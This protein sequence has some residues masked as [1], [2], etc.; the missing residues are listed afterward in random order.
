MDVKSELLKK[1]DAPAGRM[2]VDEHTHLILEKP[3]LFPV[4]MEIML[5]NPGRAG[6]NAAWV[7]E[8][9]VDKHPEW[10]EPYVISLIEKLPH[11]KHTSFQRQATKMLA[12]RDLPEEYLGQVYECCSEFVMGNKP[13]AV[14]IF[15]MQILYNISQL[16]PELKPELIEIIESRLEFGTPGFKNC[17]GNILK[18]LYKECGKSR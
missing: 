5:E 4:L 6:R 18:K 13:A 2:L 3:G 10:L 14:Q 8:F 16:E 11:F 17:G 12:K 7:A 15:S 1:L 9:C